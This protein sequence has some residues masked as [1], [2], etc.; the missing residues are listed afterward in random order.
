MIGDLAARIG[1]A[2]Y[3]SLRVTPVLGLISGLLIYFKM[4]DPSRG[5]LE[6]DKSTRKPT[7]WIKDLH[8]LC[9]KW[10]NF[11]QIMLFSLQVL[12][13]KSML[14]GQILNILVIFSKT[15]ILSS[16]ALFCALFIQNRLSWWAPGYINYGLGLQQLKCL[17]S[18]DINFP[19]E[20]YSFISKMAVWL[21]GVPLGVTVAISLRRKFPHADPLVCAIGLLLGCPMVYGAAYGARFSLAFG[22]PFLFLGQILLKWNEAL[23]VDML[24]YVVIPTKRCTALAIQFLLSHALGYGLNWMIIGWIKEDSSASQQFDFIGI[25]VL[26]IGIGLFFATTFYVV[27]DRNLCKKEISEEEKN[28]QKE[29]SGM[30]TNV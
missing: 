10:A 27:Q 1:G 19:V 9:K 29:V 28:S 30:P 4:D 11:N 17:T 13:I 18:S 2:W 26:L 7:W 6:G 15:F 12:S 22:L 25:L 3:W 24:L 16:F 20:S 5:K 23:V 21:I 8:Y 14:I